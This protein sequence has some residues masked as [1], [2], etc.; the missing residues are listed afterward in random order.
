[1]MM[2]ICRNCWRGIRHIHRP[3]NLKLLVRSADR[4]AKRRGV[5][6]ASDSYIKRSSESFSRAYCEEKKGNKNKNTKRTASKTPR[7]RVRSS[8]Q[9]GRGP[10]RGSPIFSLHRHHQP[11]R[12]PS[13]SG[14][15]FARSF[16]SRPSLTEPPGASSC[17][18]W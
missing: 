11:R 18:L 1:M 3:R 15:F 8:F 2:T 7:I 14:D 5:Y 10:T 12:I 6:F 9:D 16:P 13:R 4:A 17:L